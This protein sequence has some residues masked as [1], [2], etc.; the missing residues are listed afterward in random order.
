MSIQVQDAK[1]RAMSDQQI[2]VGRNGVPNNFF[3]VQP[4]LKSIANVVRGVGRAKYF[5]AFYLNRLMF[6]VD[7]PL[8]EFVNKVLSRKL[9]EGTITEHLYL[10]R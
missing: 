5:N 2:N 8:F 3:I 4:I 1:R 9:S 7:A 10:L 6:K